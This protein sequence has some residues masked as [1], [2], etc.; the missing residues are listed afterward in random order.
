MP[1]FIVHLWL[2]KAHDEAPVSGS[3]ILAGVLLKLGSYGLLRVSPVLFKFG[4]SFVQ[5]AQA[6]SST[7]VTIRNSCGASGAVVATESQVCESAILLCVQDPVNSLEPTGCSNDCAHIRLC[8]SY[9]EEPVTVAH[10][11]DDNRP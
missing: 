10:N 1:M 11:G 7:Y 9:F 6:R 3:I 2:P 5:L 4:L 8:R